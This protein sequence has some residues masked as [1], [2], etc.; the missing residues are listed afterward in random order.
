M[1]STP[2]TPDGRNPVDYLDG[3]F[4]GMRARAGKMLERADDMHEMSLILRAYIASTQQ[5]GDSIEEA[6]TR[7]MF[8]GS[9]LGLIARMYG[10]VADAVLEYADVADPLV[11]RFS[12]LANDIETAYTK[13]ADAEEA[14]EIGL[15]PED[16]EGS[17]EDF[18]PDAAVEAARLAWEA[19]CTQYDTVFAQWRD[20]YI[21]ASEK[22]DAAVKESR[23]SDTDD[24]KSRAALDKLA[25]KLKATNEATFGLLPFSGLAE[26]VTTSFR[27]M[28]GDA[29]AKD[30]FFSA[31][32]AVPGAK[33][34]GKAVDDAL[35][36]GVDAAR[37]GWKNTEE[38]VGDLKTWGDKFS[39]KTIEGLTGIKNA[40]TASGARVVVGFM[41]RSNEALNKGKDVVEGVKSWKDKIAS[42]DVDINIGVP[43]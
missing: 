18:D 10:D 42:I 40:A 20:A 9:T 30:V 27:A 2:A 17:F 26:F 34:L 14:K 8:L 13:L 4:G 15:P 7:A 6:K 5:E 29:G 28:D 37:A 23:I 32:G 19:L 41:A 35:K 33:V 31:L 12:S 16:F 25:D 1:V 3:D 39:Q 11:S 43:W 24:Q 36:G 21:G 22:V 38:F